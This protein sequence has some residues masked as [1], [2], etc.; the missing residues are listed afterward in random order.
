MEND[1][2]RG[3]W[4]TS[5]AASGAEYTKVYPYY[6]TMNLW[7]HKY[8]GKTVHRAETLMR[9]THEGKQYVCLLV[10]EV[11]SDDFKDVIMRT[12]DEVYN[13]LNCHRINKDLIDQ[14]F[15]QEDRL[16]LS[17]RDRLIEIHSN[18]Y[19]KKD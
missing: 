17:E 18:R 6:P 13:F 14:K 15:F 4:T 12:H 16:Q 19:G 9:V 7:D 2:E 3:V 5:D 1:L 11:M 8:T 10:E